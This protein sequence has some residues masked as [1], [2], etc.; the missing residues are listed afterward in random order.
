LSFWVICAA[1]SAL[2]INQANEAELDSLKGMGPTLSRHVLKARAEGEFQNWADVLRRVSGMGRSKAKQFS[3]QGLVV[4]GQ[5]FP[6][7]R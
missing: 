7:D 1:A 4:N 5:P 3:G 2:E 6:S